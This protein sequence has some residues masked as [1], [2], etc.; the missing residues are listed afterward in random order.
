MF[1]DELQASQSKLKKLIKDSRKYLT[2]FGVF[3]IIIVSQSSVKLASDFFPTLLPPADCRELK[4]T[5]H[6]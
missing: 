1:C 3:L 5:S 6:Q 4:L 2:A